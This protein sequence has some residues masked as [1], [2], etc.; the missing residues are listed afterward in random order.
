M[1]GRPFVTEHRHL[2]QR[3]MNAE[4]G[5][6]A[7]KSAQHLFGGAGFAGAVEFVVEVSHRQMHFAVESVRRRRHGRG[8]G[9]PHRGGRTGSGEQLWHLSACLLHHLFIGA[10][11]T[12]LAQYADVRPLLRRDHRLGKARIRQ[13]LHL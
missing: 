11:K 13:R 3:R 1:V 8:I 5:F 6:I 9:Y 4:T 2:R 7:K 12:E 10:G